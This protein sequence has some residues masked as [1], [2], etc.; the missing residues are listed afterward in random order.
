MDPI[1]FRPVEDRTP[2]RSVNQGDPFDNISA[3]CPEVL[4][5]LSLHVEKFNI[6]D[7]VA[8]YTE[9]V[10]FEETLDGLVS[11]VMRDV[12]TLEVSCVSLCLSLSSRSRSLFRVGMR[13]YVY[14]SW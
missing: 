2:V 1:S 12:E 5:R 11:V 3:T 10:S 8:F 6:R 14:A 4:A 13:V 7:R 9:V